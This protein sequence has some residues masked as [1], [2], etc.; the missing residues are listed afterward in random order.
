MK[1]LEIS[2]DASGVTYGFDIVDEE[3]NI[4]LSSDGFKTEQA[5][6]HEFIYLKELFNAMIEGVADEVRMVD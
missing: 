4:L 6:K 5:A 2:L 1:R 3:N